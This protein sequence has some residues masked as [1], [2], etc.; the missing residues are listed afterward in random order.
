MRK[1]FIAADSFWF[2]MPY[3]EGSGGGTTGLVRVDSGPF[4]DRGPKVRKLAVTHG[5][6]WRILRRKLSI[7]LGASAA[8]MR[9][10]TFGR[11]FGSNDPTRTRSRS[12]P[13]D[14]S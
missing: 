2:A 11:R 3:H 7:C 5:C 6:C 12:L 14:R 4:T 1:H 9:T 13:N 10:L 8:R